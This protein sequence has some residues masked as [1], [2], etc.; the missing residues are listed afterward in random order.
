MNHEITKGAPG[1]VLPLFILALL[2]LQ[3]AVKS[4]DVRA[5]QIDILHGETLKAWQSLDLP[6]RKVAVE[7]HADVL[8]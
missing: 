1:W 7:E 3:L 2:V 4:G 5:Q 6:A 8:G